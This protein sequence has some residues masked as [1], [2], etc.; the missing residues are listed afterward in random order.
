MRIS[1]TTIHQYESPKKSGMHSGGFTESF[2]ENIWKKP[3]LI[4]REKRGSDHEIIMEKAVSLKTQTL[5]S[6]FHDKTTVLL[7]VENE[8]PDG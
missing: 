7:N 4:T 6:N 3:K 5:T 2:L 1:P 8:S